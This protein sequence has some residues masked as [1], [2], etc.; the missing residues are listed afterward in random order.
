MSTCQILTEEQQESARKAGKILADCLV[1]LKDHTKPGIST[2]ELDVIAEE[3]IQDHGGESAFKGYQGFPC[4]LCTSI[5][6]G[7]VHGIPS[8]RVLEEGDIASL[9]CGVLLDGIYTDS[10]RTYP[11]GSI[12][13]DAQKLLDVTE[14]ALQEALTVVKAGVKSGDIS[15]V[16]QQYVEKRGFKPVVSLTGHGLGDTLHQPPDIPNIGTAGT[17]LTIPAGAL[18]A[19]EPIISAGSDHIVES[20]DNWTLSIQDGGLSAHFEHSLLVTD[21]GYELIA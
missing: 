10:C 14:G 3:F 17:G 13:A 21:D 4:T 11:V 7:C 9:D 12:S 16:I 19:I 15:S 8:D 1:M 2:I 5:N 6:D 20:S 18:I